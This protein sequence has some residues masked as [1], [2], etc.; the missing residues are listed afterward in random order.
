MLKL[1][2]QY[3]GHLMRRAWLIGKDPDAGKDWRQEKGTTENEMVGWHHQLD[4]HEFE[5][6][7]GDSEGQGSLVCCSLWGCKETGR[8]QW[9]NN[10]NGWKRNKSL[11]WT[12]LSLARELGGKSAEPREW[13]ETEAGPRS[14]SVRRWLS[15]VLLHPSGVCEIT[16][17]MYWFWPY[18]QSLP[19]VLAQSS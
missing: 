17:S 9:P 11:Q 7:L 5:Q 8:T 13:G 15:W 4:G 6:T 3:F 18:V 19:L 10:S 1:K 16:E 14:Q 12:S 2:L